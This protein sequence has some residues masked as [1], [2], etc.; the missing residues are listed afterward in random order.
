MLVEVAL[1]LPVHTLFTYRVP[2][3]LKGEVRV[4]QRVLVP[5]RNH[6][7]KGIIVDVG[8]NGASPRGPARHW[9]IGGQASSPE[10]LKEIRTLLNPGLSVSQIH[11]RLTRWIAE[12]Y[13]CGWGEALSVLA[14]AFRKSKRVL[15]DPEEAG[16]YPVEDKNH[17]LTAEQ[18][19]A[20]SAVEAAVS[21]GGFKTFLLFGVT[22]SGKTEVYLRAMAKAV[23]EGTKPS[24]RPAAES[25]SGRPAAGALPGRPATEASSGKQALF[26]VP[27]ISLC[28]PFQHILTLRFGNRVGVWH[29]QISSRERQAVVEGIRNGTVDI[30]VGARSALFAPLDRLGIIVVDEEHD[31]SYKQQ[32]K[33]RYHAR[34][35]A[36][37]LAELHGCAAIFG[38]ATPS[39]EIFYKAEK[40]EIELLKMPQRIPTHSL[41]E[42]T[43]VDR[44]QPGSFDGGARSFSPFTPELIEAVTTALTRREQVILA[45]NRR[46]FS[47]FL[48]CLACG[49]VFKCPAATTASARRTCPANAKGAARRP[50]FWAVS[51]PRRS[52]RKSKRSFP[53]RASSVWTATRPEGKPSRPKPTPRSG[54]NRPTSWSALKW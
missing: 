34:E 20:V 23:G 36:L 14:P 8:G 53:T 12:T 47:T 29:S 43:L 51:G 7:L 25:S 41:P 2:E 40:G 44:R 5:F 31:S 15:A 22:S 35:A 9:G 16:S 54:K 30:V 4:G 46:G 19:P 27:E 24:G 39:L 6:S 3:A 45:L 37:K 18:L 11:L 10:K 49:F 26:L 33:P 17:E 42:I 13:G 1:P 50:S 38:S 48:I 28:R 21:K 52:F 32:E